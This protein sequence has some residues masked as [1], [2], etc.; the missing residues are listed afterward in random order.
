MGNGA[1]DGDIANRK[2]VVRCLGRA[3]AS[4]EATPRLVAL[5]DDFG[6]IFLVL[7]LARERKLVFGLA[8][9]DFVN[10]EPL[11]RGAY[12]AG[13]MAL[14]VLDVVQFGREWVLHVDDEDFPV[15]LA[16]VEERHDPEDLDLLDLSNVP[17]L[18]PNLADV[19][20]IVVTPGLG[21][22]MLLSGILPRLGESTVIPDVPVVGKA[23]AHEAQAAL[24]DI[25]L[26]G[27][28]RLLLGNFHLGIRPAGNFDNHVEYAIAL[29]GEE[30]NIVERRDDLAVLLDI[31]AMLKGVGGTD[32]ARCVLGRHYGGRKKAELLC[33]ST[34]HTRRHV[35]ADQ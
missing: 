21:L 17:D 30:G 20:R 16:L 18:L 3:L 1:V 19:Q 24:L 5:M 35:D 26:D 28:E 7:R 33:H 34:G 10:T 9:G 14:D 8:I 23:V 6:S 29:I 32:E 2:I 12:E 13:Q 15:R 25:L 4:N 31:D 27:V 11:I 22:S